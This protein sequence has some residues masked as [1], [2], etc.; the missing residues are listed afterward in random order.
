[1]MSAS[2][3]VDT[4][5]MLGICESKEPR[6]SLR[7]VPWKEIGQC[8]KRHYCELVFISANKDF[9]K[10][11]GALGALMSLLR[12]WLLPDYINSTSFHQENVMNLKIGPANSLDI[13]PCANCFLIACCVSASS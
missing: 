7:K 1:M 13:F 6:T 2:K 9:L 10:L 3:G 4:T 12:D 5:E 11:T 8:R